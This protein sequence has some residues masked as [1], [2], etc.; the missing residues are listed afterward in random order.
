M[1]SAKHLLHMEKEWMMS[2]I[3]VLTSGSYEDE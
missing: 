1:P 2:E 3:R